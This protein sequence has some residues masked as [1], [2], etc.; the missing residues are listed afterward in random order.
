MLTITILTD[1]TNC[2]FIFVIINI[3]A[4][5]NIHNTNNIIL[6]NNINGGMDYLNYF[7]IFTILT[8]LTI[9][10]LHFFF[11]LIRLKSYLVSVNINSLILANYGH[12]NDILTILTYSLYF[13]LYLPTISLFIYTV[14]YYYKIY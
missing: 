3:C 9:L 11:I 1:N 7:I 10:F 5:H 8:I 12:T 4:L 14:L 2:F 13:F 6:T